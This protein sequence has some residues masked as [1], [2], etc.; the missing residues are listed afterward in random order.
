M[1]A[2]PVQ[3]LKFASVGA[4]ATLA[5]YAV[6]LALKEGT[7]I[8]AVVAS[9]I[10]ALIGAGVSYL[11]NY[12]YTF[13]AKAAHTRTLP[14]FLT[15]AAVAFILNLALMSVGVWGLGLPYFPVQLCAT[16]HILIVTFTANKVWT[17]G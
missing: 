11:L 16:A 9:A 4:A 1:R 14:R 10:G 12:R 17:F 5:H 8:S 15:I 2:L 13:A 6:L 3:F 7:G